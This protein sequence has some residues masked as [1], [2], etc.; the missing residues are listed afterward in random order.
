[1]V[2][3]TKFQSLAIISVSMI[4]LLVVSACTSEG[5]SSL[6]PYIGGNKAVDMEFLSGSPRSEIFDGG[7]EE[8]AVAVQIRNVGEEDIT[9]D[10]GYV[11]VTGIL[12]QEY[13]VSTSDLTQRIPEI[14]GARMRS[15]TP[16]S[17]GIET[18]SFD[19]LAYQSEIAGDLTSQMVKVSACYNYKTRVTSNICVKENPYDSRGR[20]DIC[21]VEG[22]RQVANS[23]API[24][25]T[26][27]MQNVGGINSIQVRMEISHTGNAEDYFFKTDTDC[28]ARDGNSDMYRV[29]V[30]VKPIVNGQITPR[31]SGLQEG[32]GSTGYVTLFDGQSRELICNF[33]LSEVEGSSVTPL[34]VELSY[35][36]MQS[37][38]KPITIRAISRSER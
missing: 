37:I 17:G 27:M 11:R 16:I 31:C 28:E 4:L 15:S 21:S 5:D 23:G 36:Y 29:Y 1:M 12:A 2:M 20:D 26:R 6:S 10:D 14:P 3:R 24:Q 32:D 13:G 19:G 7:T 30:D 35:R 38:E 34:N 33:D 25:I 18:V 22:Q 9:A 8:F